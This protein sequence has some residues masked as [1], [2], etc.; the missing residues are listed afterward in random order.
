MRNDQLLQ[1]GEG[2]DTPVA[3]SPKDDGSVVSDRMLKQLL[4]T[5]GLVGGSFFMIGVVAGALHPLLP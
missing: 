5:F 3:E 2:E 4:I 1:N